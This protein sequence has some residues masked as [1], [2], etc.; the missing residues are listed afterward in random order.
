M[1][2]INPERLR[3]SFETYSEIGE[4]E[5]GGLH[6]LTLS[7]A[8]KEARDQFVTDL[9]SLG[10]EIR[11]DRVGNI[12]GRRSGE[13][14]DSAPVMI[15]SH[16]DSQPYGGRY[17]GQ[18]G[19]LI[20]LETLRAL[21]DED[22]VTDR[23]IEIVNWTNEEGARFKPALLGS[24][25]F[26]G[27]FDIEEVLATTDTDG[28]SIGEELERIG[29]AGD[30]PCKPRDIYAF[31]ELHI[32]QGPFLTESGDS[33]GVVEGVLGMAWL[34]A[35][36]TGQA[37][38]AGPSPMHNRQD[39]LSAATDVIDEVG[40]L[41]QRLAPD[42]RTTVGE[43]SV[44]PNSINVIPEEVRFTVD[45][46]SYSESVVQRGIEEIEAELRRACERTNTT[47]ELEK[48]WHIPH[49][50]FSAQVRDRVADAAVKNGVEYQRML[51]GAGHD[52]KYLNDI[53]DAGMIFVPSADGL[54]HC[55]EEFTPW[56]DILA[57]ARTYADTVCALATDE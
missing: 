23:P 9:K 2:N 43:V 41:P 56:E 27:Q 3:R 14:S 34:N 19:V 48:V 26:V 32:E 25:A 13:D 55:E 21:D 11:I 30:D 33:V 28:K 53:T 1:T 22:I 4:T 29:Y 47:Y 17:D 52:A 54:T 6:R 8:D 36:I 46:R 37:D 16:L 39:A 44:S 18:I 20:A 15:G 10:L 57:G 31:L 50:D 7:D 38:H 40:S 42:A 35:T 5:D 51:S 45:V 24:G 49:T 12:F